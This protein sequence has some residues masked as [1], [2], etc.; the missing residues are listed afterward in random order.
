MHAGGTWLVAVIALG[1]CDQVFQLDGR[2]EDADAA[3]AEPCPPDGTYQPLADAPTASRYRFVDMPATW[4]R[5]FDDCRNDSATGVTHLIV[6]DD[7]SEFS[8]VQAAAFQRAR[9]GWGAWAGYARDW[10]TPP[11]Q[12]RAVTGEPIAPSSPLWAASEPD[13]GGP[14]GSETV[15]RWGEA[16]D[17]LV[18]APWDFAAPDG[19]VC[20]CDGTPTNGIE[21]A[22]RPP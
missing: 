22:I 4:S 2:T 21:F 19:Y 12:F 16:F 20:E 6:F 15:V 13:N 14:D 18:D 5:A 9:V 7:T 1:G 10:N 3:P 11:F 8:V 17:G